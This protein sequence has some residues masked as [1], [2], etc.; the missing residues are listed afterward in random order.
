MFTSQ[1]RS[2]R[3]PGFVEFIALIASLMS[4]QALAVDAMLPAFP[5]I[6]EALHVRDANRVQWVLSAYMIGLGF[7]QLLW[8]T[9]SDRFGRRA[10]LLVGIA[11]YFAAALACALAATLPALMFWRFLHGIAAASVTVCRSVIRDLYQG[12]QMARVLSLTFV[13]FL[14]MPMLAPSLGAA[15]LLAA[16]WRTIFSVCAMLAAAVF[17]WALVRL[18]ETLHAEYRSALSASQIKSAARLV[19]TNRSSLCYSLAVTAIFGSLLTYVA[20]VQQIFSVTFARASLMPRIFAL[21]AGMMGLAAFLNSRIVERLGMRMISHSALLA[22]I[23]ISG[24]HVLVVLAGLENLWTFAILQAATMACTGLASSNFGAMAMEPLGSVAG[25][26]ASLQG[27]I[28]ILG[29]AVIG[30]ALGRLFHGT[31]LPLAGGTFVCAL[32]ALALVLLAEKGKL[33]QPHHPEK[34]KQGEAHAV[35]H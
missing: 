15:I 35:P 23:F 7:G 20:T 29:A 2:I 16:G 12:R 24:V 33:F 32:C 34:C 18:P 21:C 13:V 30:A 27:F 10:I 4:I 22:L 28:S 1:V 3:A 14:L 26:A 17:F 25:I 5:A 19:L 6:I 11:A 8:G 31:T 9:L